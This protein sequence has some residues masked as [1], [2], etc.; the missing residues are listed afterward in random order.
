MRRDFRI[1]IVKL[2]GIG[3]VRFAEKFVI[4]NIPCGTFS[5]SIYDTKYLSIALG[6]RTDDIKY[7][8][9]VDTVSFHG[10]LSQ[11]KTP[12]VK[13]RGKAYTTAMLDC[14]TRMSV[15]RFISVQMPSP[16]IDKPE[17]DKQPLIA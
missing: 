16:M 1:E 5:V 12:A 3:V 13:C 17:S 6:T 9:H 10:Q 15:T 4:G 11:M 7:T 8:M 2:S 14:T